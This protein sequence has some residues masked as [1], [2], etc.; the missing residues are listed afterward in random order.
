MAYSLSHSIR[1]AV[2]VRAEPADQFHLI[3]PL[4][5]RRNVSRSIKVVEEAMVVMRSTMLPH[6]K[7]LHRL[8]EQCGTPHEA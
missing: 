4:M 5:S 2:P 1:R 3:E 7:V 8:P 6:T